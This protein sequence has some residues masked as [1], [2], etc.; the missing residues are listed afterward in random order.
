MII[1]VYNAE[2]HLAEA[3]A[4][5][6]AQTFGDWECV[7]VDDGSADSSPEILARFASDSR[8]RIIRQD[9]AGPGASR[10]RALE[11]I[12]SP[13]FFFMDSDDLLHP[14]ALERL[15][16][17]A[18][19]HGAEIAEASFTG[20]KDELSAEGE[21]VVV[22]DPVGMM[23]GERSWRGT[24]WGRLYKTS[25]FAAVRFPPWNNHEDVAWATEVFTVVSRV[26]VVSSRLYF[27]RPS[28]GGLSRSPKAKAGLPALWRRQAG[29]CPRLRPRLGEVAYGHW[30]GDPETFGAGLLY[31]LK[32]DG[33]ISFSG[34]SLS[35]KFRILLS[36]IMK[37]G[38]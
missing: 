38:R 19:E 10:N 32:K 3:L 36:L 15:V 30:K 27:Y 12:R 24:V 26:A 28:P 25:S 7:C 20:S 16:A 33:V 23:C 35:K 8:F 2:T 1:P 37:R 34:L 9:N 14:R 11:S 18:E 4:S 29:L 6:R 13:W 22:D 17:V 31:R 21:V 5:V